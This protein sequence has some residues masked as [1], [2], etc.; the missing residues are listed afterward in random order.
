MRIAIIGPEATGKTTLANRLAA[1]F[2]G[3]ATEEYARDYFISRKLPADHV[4]SV[5]EMREV[6]Q[7]QQAVE[8]EAWTKHP[9]KLVFVDASTINGPLYAGLER[10]AKG[11]LAFDLLTVDEEVMEAGRSGLYDAFLLCWPHEDLPWENDGLRAMPSLRD[12]M[13]FANGCIAF[14]SQHYLTA[15]LLAVDA[16]TWEEREWQAI[17]AV[18]ALANG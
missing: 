17:Q 3:V 10:D 18:T 16:G 11:D 8:F 12:R 13:R 4:L 7:G 6:M 9:D 1:H 15:P 5:E 2:G 14:A